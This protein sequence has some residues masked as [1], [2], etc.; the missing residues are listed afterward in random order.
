MNKSCR[1]SMAFPP[2][3]YYEVDVPGTD[4]QPEDRP[5]LTLRTPTTF[6]V[7]FMYG[8][9]YFTNFPRTSVLGAKAALPL[10]ITADR[11]EQVNLAKRRPVRVAEIELAVSALPKQ[12]TRKAHLAARADDQ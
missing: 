3:G 1:G 7:L 11:A 12:K 6:P 8:A 4:D 2:I 10:L 5:S 9:L